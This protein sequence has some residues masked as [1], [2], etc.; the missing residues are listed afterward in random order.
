[1]VVADP[2]R[3]TLISLGVGA[4]F[5]WSLYALFLGS[6]GHPGMRDSF[7]LTAGAMNGSHTARVGNTWTG[8]SA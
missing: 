5:L 7:T 6:A 8:N 4:A 3:D 1:M 2:G